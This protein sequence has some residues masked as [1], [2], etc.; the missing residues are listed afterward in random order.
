MFTSL[1]C[2]LSLFY[3]KK[4]CL[5]I[6]GETLIY[7]TAMVDVLLEREFNYLLACILRVLIGQSENQRQTLT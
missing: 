1:L 4:T 5:R 7:S 3:N 6:C 2:S